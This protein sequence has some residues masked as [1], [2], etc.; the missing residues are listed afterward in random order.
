MRTRCGLDADWTGPPGLPS[1]PPKP[2]TCTNTG[3]PRE[4]RTHNPRNKRPRFLSQRLMIENALTCANVG[5]ARIEL[6]TRGL[7]VDC[8]GARCAWSEGRKWVRPAVMPSDRS[9][10]FAPVVDLLRTRCGLCGDTCGLVSIFARSPNWSQSLSDAPLGRGRHRACRTAADGWTRRSGLPELAHGDVDSWLV[11]PGPRSAWMSG[12]CAPKCLDPVPLATGRVWSHC[13]HTS[14]PLPRRASRTR[15]SDAVEG[16]GWCYADSA[17]H[18]SRVNH[19]R[20][21]RV[22]N[23]VHA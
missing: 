6:A 8:A 4:D 9:R 15:W 13:G 19:L 10:W 23:R 20:L 5:P 22:V 21:R 1:G 2:L 18:G 17:R 11:E 3:R 14:A 12:T 16:V 7:K